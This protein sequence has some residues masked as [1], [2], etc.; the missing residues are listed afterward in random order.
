MTCQPYEFSLTGELTEELTLWRILVDDKL[1]SS[2][3]QPFS[4][5]NG[6]IECS[7][8]LICG[9]P[10]CGGGWVAARRV[11]PYVIWF[12]PFIQLDDLHGASPGMKAGEVLIFDA[13]QY[14]KMVGN[15]D[16]QTLPALS[17]DE[18][19]LLILAELPEPGLAL[20]C[21]P[22]LVGD[23]RGFKLLQRAQQALW[24]QAETI[25]V[26]SEPED[27]TEIHLGLDEFGV[28]ECVWRIGKIEPYWAIMFLARPRLPVWLGGEA[29]AAIFASIVLADTC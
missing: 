21:L 24:N 16:S 29:I 15:G 7:A 10:G 4:A 2:I 28:P 6:D 5:S 12:R 26:V 23:P 14:A 20:Y 1:F 27:W 11:G 18:L 19:K 22:E 9:Y 17:A 3:V 25:M 8:C 13:E